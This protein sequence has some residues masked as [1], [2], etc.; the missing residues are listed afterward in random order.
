MKRYYIYWHTPPTN[1]KHQLFYYFE[2]K[3]SATAEAKILNDV[4]R[5]KGIKH[6]ILFTEDADKTPPD[7]ITQ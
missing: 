7:I 2:D 6:L 4:W 5:T 1:L 3:D